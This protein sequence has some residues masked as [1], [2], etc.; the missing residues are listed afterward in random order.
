LKPVTVEQIIGLGATLLIMLVGALG[1]FLPG[2]PGTPLVLVAAVLHR[3]YFGPT[4]ANNWVLAGLVILT[5]V[6]LVFDYLAT[7]YGAKRLGATWRGM[8]GAVLG[9]LVGCFFSLPGILLGPFVGAVLLELAGRREWKIA[10]RAGVGA[11][12]GLV[13]GAMGKLAICLAMVGLFLA[14][15]IYRSAG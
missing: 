11:T 12:V 10:F 7:V 8:V 14:N 4:G 5:L 15:V 2:I 6:S 1:S 3:L 9:G 13:A